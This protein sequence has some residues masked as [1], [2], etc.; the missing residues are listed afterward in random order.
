MPPSRIE[1]LRGFIAQRPDDPF[2][3]YALAMEHKNAGQLDAAWETFKMLMDAHPEYVPGYLHAGNT[4]VALGRTT[5]AREVFGQGVAAS[6]RSG[7]GHARGE[8]EAAL[9]ALGG[10]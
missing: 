2:P 5:E 6:N 9:A 4:L 3:R 8:L 10:A 1:L 7:D